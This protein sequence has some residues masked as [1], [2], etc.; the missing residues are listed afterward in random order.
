MIHVKDSLLPM[1]KV[2]SLDFLGI[3]V[4]DTFIQMLSNEAFFSDFPTSTPKSYH[5]IFFRPL[6]VNRLCFIFKP[7]KHSERNFCGV[8]LYFG[9]MPWNMHHFVSRY[10]GMTKLHDFTGSKNQYQFQW[11][12]T[13]SSWKDM[14]HCTKGWCI[15][16]QRILQRWIQ[17]RFKWG[18]QNQSNSSRP[19]FELKT[20]I[21]W[22]CSLLSK[23][24]LPMP[25]AV[26]TW[27]VHSSES[28]DRAWHGR[29]LK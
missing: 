9:P 13:R 26:A 21:T 5:L 18:T 8:H 11:K 1:G 20:G 2:W 23:A 17:R 12:F 4:G 19:V 25:L 7:W 16:G 15:L 22:I 24:L 14:F 10:L 28:D 3:Y 6:L 29:K 27:T